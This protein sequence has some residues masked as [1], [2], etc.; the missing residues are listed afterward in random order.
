MT[1]IEIDKLVEK[2]AIQGNINSETILRELD[3]SGVQFKPEE[4]IELYSSLFAS[5]RFSITPADIIKLIG[6]IGKESTPQSVLDICC[7]T[8]SILSQFESAQSLTGIDINEDILKLAERFYPNAQI[9]AADIIDLD[10]QNTVYDL[11]VGD[12]PY[13]LP[14]RTND[15]GE[16]AILKKGLTLIK[17]NGT[18]IFMIPD[19]LLRSSFARE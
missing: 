16:L 8:A 14:S 18:G 19:T 4:I 6:H 5:R 13:A 1:E 3:N 9:I 17:E 7:G 12:I 10:F 11:V 15:P 2:I